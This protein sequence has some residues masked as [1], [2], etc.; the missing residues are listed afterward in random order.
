V[1]I[2]LVDPYRLHDSVERNGFNKI[3]PTPTRYQNE[4]KLHG[5][6]KQGVDTVFLGNSRTELG[7][8]PEHVTS[9]GSAYNLALAGTRLSTARSQLAHL[10]DEGVTPKT[11][12]V[13]LE[14]L[15]FLIQPAKSSPVAVAKPKT[16]RDDL[17]WRADALFSID[18]L[19]DSLKTLRLQRAEYPQSITERGFNPLFEYN[20]F[21]REGGYYPIFQQRAGEYANRFVQ[22]SRKSPTVPMGN[23]PDLIALRNII[24]HGIKTEA[25][26]HLVI[27]PYHVQIMAMLE[28]AGLMN[29][30]DD[31]KAMLVREVSD[32]LRANPGARV[33]LWDF[34]GYS[35]YQCE[36]IPRKGDKLTKTMWYWEAGHFKDALGQK[37][38]TRMFMDTTVLQTF[39]FELDANNS[40]LNQAR[41]IGERTACVAAHPEI[42]RNASALISNARGVGRPTQ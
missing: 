4:I 22:A 30:F 16:V 18:S 17:A 23:S 27:Y 3:K 15:D 38:L 25:D 36:A 2:A 12:I 5:A 9:G 41:I 19:I 8:N 1:F 11:L 42:F 34:S 40:A 32:A 26:I 29:A 20:K 7:F 31:W 37:M 21:A 13:G 35:A 39:G 33:R 6:V 24:I 14:F 28:E 10:R